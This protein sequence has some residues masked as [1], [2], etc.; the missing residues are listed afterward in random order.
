MTANLLAFL[1]Q[2][3][4]GCWK[5]GFGAEEVEKDDGVHYDY[6]F[7][8][9]DLRLGGFLSVAPLKLSYFWNITDTF[10]ENNL[11]DAKKENVRNCNNF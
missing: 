9:Y 11:M 5:C 2:G 7:R 8:I 6:R 10:A 4:F 3:C 1:R